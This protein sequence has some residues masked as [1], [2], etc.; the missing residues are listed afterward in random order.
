VAE[1]R[2][3][4]MGKIIEDARAL[5]QKILERRA[6]IEGASV[7]WKTN[8]EM[9]HRF[10][11][12][13]IDDESEF[14]RYMTANNAFNVP[15]HVDDSLCASMTQKYL[16]HLDRQG[17]PLSSLPPHIAESEMVAPSTV[18]RHDGRPI[19]TLFLLHLCCA[20]RVNRHTEGLKTVLEIGAGHGN[21]ARIMRLFYPELTYYIVDVA[22]SLYCSYVFLA[23]H[24]PDRRLLF[25]TDEHQL[26][27]S[28][29]HDFVFVPAEMA[30]GL[31]GKTFDLVMNTCSLGEMSQ[32]TVDGYM[33][34]VNDDATVR[35]F[36][37]VN[38]YGPFIPDEPPDFCNVPV[39]LS[40]DWS[41]LVWDVFG[42]NS[43]YQIEPWAPP[44]LEILAKKWIDAE[45]SDHLYMSLAAHLFSLAQQMETP[46]SAWHYCMWNAIR[47]A[48]SCDIIH[49]YLKVA[50]RG[51]YRN[52]PYFRE[53]YMR[54]P[55]ESMRLPTGVSFDFAKQRQVQARAHAQT[56]N[57]LQ[58]ARAQLAAAHAQTE[59]ERAELAALRSTI[60]WKITSPLRAIRRAFR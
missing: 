28:A 54:V 47:Y 13:T 17:T 16:E 60:S 21:L 33:R 22:D 38:R 51:A 26:Q 23:S 32:K 9:L 37:S 8:L 50:E 18:F 24:F 14:V 5:R 6:P 48:P 3:E 41:V 20:L 46:N 19:S 39:N 4:E 27:E 35:Y 52:A 58:E 36:Y 2:G 30:A 56:E 10:A 1:I 12:R 40:R 55:A 15:R 25:V 7:Y 43:F 45:N 57:D 42:E 34:L 53:L 11:I 44:Y 49:E 31:R 29:D 59:H